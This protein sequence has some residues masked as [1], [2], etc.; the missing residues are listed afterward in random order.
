MVVDLGENE[1]E[2]ELEAWT[3]FPIKL[4]NLTSRFWRMHKEFEINFP[5]VHYL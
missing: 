4:D 3:I 1:L 2:G 5:I